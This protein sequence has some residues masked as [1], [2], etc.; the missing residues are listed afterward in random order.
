MI[1]SAA[2]SGEISGVPNS[3]GSQFSSNRVST[4]LGAALVSSSRYGELMAVTSGD[5]RCFPIRSKVGAL[6]G[7]HLLPQSRCMLKACHFTDSGFI[8]S[9]ASPTGLCDNL[10]L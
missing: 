6:T 4:T 7:S 3:L 2:V 10:H 1:L 5:T 8:S 9:G